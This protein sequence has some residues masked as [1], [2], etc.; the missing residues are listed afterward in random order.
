VRKGILAGIVSV[1]AAVLVCLGLSACADTNGK[2]G[3][4]ANQEV[5]SKEEAMKVISA[6]LEKRWAINDQYDSATDQDAIVEGLKK[7]I[8]AEI[9]NDSQLKSAKFDDSKLQET[10]LSYLNC[11]DDSMKEIK[12]HGYDTQEYYDAWTEAYNSRSALLKTMKDDYGLTVS[13]NYESTLDELV[14]NGNDVQANDKAEKAINGLFANVKF[15]QTDDGYG[16]Y[17]YSATVKNTSDLSF[18]NVSLVLGL[19]DSD[20]VRQ[21]ESY[22]SANTWAA[23]ETVKFEGYGTINAAQIKVEINYYE[24]AK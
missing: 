10:V 12:E 14:A 3:D 23:G 2:S 20:G 16:N 15:E 1:V 19:Y 17:T 9:D 5:V 11:L 6:G 18:E 13:K 21:G 22:V 4:S 8:Q 24:V 7:A